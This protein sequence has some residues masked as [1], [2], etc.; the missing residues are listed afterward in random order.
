MG[1]AIAEAFAAEQACVILTAEAGQEAELQKVT[2]QLV[3][4]LPFN[5]SLPLIDDF[6]TMP[7]EEQAAASCKQK[8]AAGVLLHC[9]LE[10]AQGC[11]PVFPPC[12]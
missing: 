10:R 7:R 4:H 8:G 3:I 6:L 2:A 5:S 9:R 12:L 1:Q 11:C